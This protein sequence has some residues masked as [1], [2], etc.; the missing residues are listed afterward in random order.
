MSNISVKLFSIWTIGSGE[1]AVLLE[2]FHLELYR[3]LYLTD[4]FT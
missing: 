2:H 1:N 3:S 4:P